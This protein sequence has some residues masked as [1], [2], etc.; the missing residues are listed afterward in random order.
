VISAAGALEELAGRGGAGFP[1]LLA[2]R[3]RTNVRLAELRERVAGMEVDED[4]SVVLFGSWGRRE[5]TSQSDDDF[6]VLVDGR[7]RA[8]VKPRPDDLRAAVVGGGEREPGA[9]GG[10]GEVAFCAD[11]V[12]QVGLDEDLNRNLTRRMLLILESV[13]I[14]GAEAHRRCF[15]RVLDGY[16][17]DS[18]QDRHPPRFFI[19]DLIR[20]WR[21]I[22]VDF[23]GKEREG[24]EKWALRNAKLRTARKLLFASGLL[25]LLLCRGFRKEEI[26]PFLLD[27][28]AAPPT[29]RVAYAFLSAGA[30]DPG[31]RT[32]AAY[33]RWLAL[34]DDPDVRAQLQSL[35]REDAK[36]SPVFQEVRRLADELEA[37]LLALLFDTPMLRALVREYGIF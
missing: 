25:P 5:L 8:N 35:P 4:A 11:L 36:R 17:R 30:I 19:N 14:A 18:L 37:G 3:E 20:Y 6:L 16:L 23:V 26:R 15:E 32:L 9:H 31:V 24:P 21:T 27:Q 28:F 22:C 13:S 2:A 10:F 33:D 7:E 1:H 34:L 29:D 12:E